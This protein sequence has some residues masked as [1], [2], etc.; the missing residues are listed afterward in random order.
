MT[1]HLEAI[2]NFGETHLRVATSSEDILNKLDMKANPKRDLKRESHTDW[3]EMRK[4]SS[5][6]VGADGAKGR[7]QT[8]MATFARGMKRPQSTIQLSHEPVNQRPL[9]VG[10]NMVYENPKSC[11]YS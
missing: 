8:A 2:S 10:V 4:V 1:R 5:G 7:P 9:S 11:R 6:P 3:K